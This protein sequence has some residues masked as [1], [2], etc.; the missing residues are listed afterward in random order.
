MRTAKGKKRIFLTAFIA[1]AVAFAALFLFS[2][3]EDGTFNDKSYIDEDYIEVESLR[4]NNGSAD[5]RMSSNGDPSLYQLDIKTVP[6]NATNKKLSY[7]IPSDY[8]QYVTVSDSGLLTAHKVSDGIT[9]P[10]TVK[11]T[12]NPKASLTV[13]VIVEDVSVTGIKFAQEKISLLYNGTSGQIDVIFVPSHAIDGRSAIFTSLNENICTVN[14]TGAV[15]PVGV[16][17]ATVKVTCSTRTGKVVENFISVI[18]SYATGQY[19]LDVSGSP[20][21]NQVIG[22]FSPIDFTLLILGENVDPEPDIAWYVDT[23]RVAENQDRIQYTH[24]PSATTQITYYVYAYVTPYQGATVTL[25]SDPITVYRAFNGFTLTYDNLSSVYTPY[26][27]GDTVTFDLSA[28]DS[29]AT[30]TEYS[31]ELSEVANPKSATVVAT[32][33]PSDRNLTRRINVAGD[34]SL[35]AKGLDSFGNLVNQTMFTFSSEKFVEGDTLIVRPA[36]L[37]YGLPPDSYHWYIVECD[38]EGNYN[39]DTKTLYSDTPSDEALY[40]PLSEGTFRF[41]VTAS[42]DGV[43]ATVQSDGKDVPYQFVSDIIRVYSPDSVDNAYA[44][45]LIDISNPAHDRFSVDYYSSIETVSIEGIG[46][47]NPYQVYIKWNNVDAN[48][49][50]IVELTYSDGTVSIIDSAEQS[51]NRFGSNYVYLS[52]SAATLNDIFSVRIKQKKGLFSRTYNYGIANDR[53][54]GDETHILTYPES[55]YTYFST[56][57]LNNASREYTLSEAAT[58][59]APALNAYIYDMADLRDLAAF[60]L[61]FRPSVNT[62]IEY[63]SSIIDSILYNSYSLDI[64]IPFTLTDAD[65]IKYPSLL[66]EEQLAA[67]GN[68]SDV[69]EMIF[70]VVNSLGYGFDFLLSVEDASPGIKITFNIPVGTDT[71][72]TLKAT[73]TE[74]FKPTLSTAYTINKTE[75]V[76][77]TY[78]PVDFKDSVTVKNSDEL[79]YAVEQGYKPVPWGNDTLPN[80]YKIIKDLVVRITEPDFT[81]KQK[82]LAFYDYLALNVTIDSEIAEVK[83]EITSEYELY[84]YKAYRLEGVFTGNKTAVDAGI[85]KAFTVMCGISGIPCYTVVA[86]VNGQERTL[87]K[88]FCESQWF[89]V[90]IAAGMRVINGYSV[91]SHDFFMLSDSDYSA[92]IGNGKVVFYG[93]AP[94]AIGSVQ[95]NTVTVYSEQ[96]LSDFLST[97]LSRPSGIY[98]IELDF[99]KSAFVDEQVVKSALSSVS[100]RNLSVANEIF[101]ISSDSTSISV[102]VLVTVKAE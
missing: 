55:V 100:L 47:E 16:G 73:G 9:I 61:L 23:E 20:N 54:A 6:S 70:G 21:F 28:G 98:G 38:E 35:T 1:A 30:I 97:A 77:S 68:Y 72:S 25:R 45:D 51:D 67:F 36:V 43:A 13:S 50:Y 62:Y 84:L 74:G 102:I 11:S 52:Q 8:H 88:V 32:T 81:D 66:T 101:V 64:Y 17:N 2:A 44:D 18:V 27:Y 91:V 56:I 19:Q 69:A 5:V 65:R 26:R 94:V 89:I 49:S 15:T 58:M 33:Y 83:E 7:Y 92:L 63:S 87:N 53:G 75:T 24:I 48:P 57:G 12:T 85:A 42:I 71:D 99:A 93:N 37:E 34:Y 40:Y 14:N 76:D 80:L 3:C 31:W 59:N 4:I 29:S 41:L 78:L 39:P 96:D 22:N 60:V 90:D 10:V 86:D 46:R 79:V 95:K 82:I